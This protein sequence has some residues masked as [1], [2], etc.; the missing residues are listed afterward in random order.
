MSNGANISPNGQHT[1][2]GSESIQ[3]G[4]YA[5]QPVMIMNQNAGG[6]SDEQQQQQQQMMNQYTGGMVMSGSQ[7]S[8]EFSASQ[9]ADG[10]YNGT[11]N[12]SGRVAREII[13]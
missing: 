1:A 3:N 11:L 2:T 8:D 6:F 4:G 5:S 9:G 7:G 12:R 10:Q 13:V